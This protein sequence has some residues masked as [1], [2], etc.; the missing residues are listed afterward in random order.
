MLLHRACCGCQYVNG[1]F[2][3]FV[4][5]HAQI[6]QI[7]ICVQSTA[8]EEMSFVSTAARNVCPLSVLTA[9]SFIKKTRN[10]LSVL[11]FAVV[12]LN[13]FT[14]LAAFREVNK[15]NKNVHVY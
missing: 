10:R 5:N 1:L 14:T 2:F 4:F 7:D 9:I 6:A 15:N 3:T 12:L 13:H 8:N 11:E